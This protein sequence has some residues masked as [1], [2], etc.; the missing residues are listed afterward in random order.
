MRQL[1]EFE[2]LEDKKISTTSA[3]FGLLR[4]ELIENLGMNRAKSFLLRYGWNL[5]QA[6][7][8]DVLKAG[9]TIKEMLEKAG[10]LHF[11]TG[12]ISNLISNR[13]VELDEYG[14]LLSITAK[15]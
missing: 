15:G 5:G 2:H 11:Q 14:N 10:E 1:E 12:Q 9:G 7:A 13:S 3:T 8:K 6:H 4:K